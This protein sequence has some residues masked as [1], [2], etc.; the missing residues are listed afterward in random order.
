MSTSLLTERYVHE[1]VRRLPADQ[2]EDIAEELRTTIAD[3]VEGRNPADPR[4]AE[5]EVLCEL[6]DPV[7]YAA[8]YTDRPLALIGPDLYPTYV[9]LLVTLLCTVLPAITFGLVVLD[10]LDDEGLG[11]ALGGGIATLFTLGCEIIAVLTVVFAVTERVRHRKGV[12]DAA[13]WTPDDLPEVRQP[14]KA[15]VGTIASAVWDALL[16]GLIIWQHTAKPYRADGERFQVL[17][18]DLWSGWVWPMLAGLAGLVVV[19]VAR[20]AARGWTVPLAIGNAVSQA[21]FTLSLAWVLHQKALFNPDFLAH[22]KDLWSSSDQ[23]YSGAALIV[24]AIGV[25]GVF[26]SFRSARG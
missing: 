5:R 6:G 16:F 21:L 2:R 7:R 12:V 15:G 10:V 22:T 14:E 13:S 25:S 3:T 19:Q 9:R 1:V 8:R 18:P 17:D 26:K 24:L 11:P 20:V 23:A 4:A